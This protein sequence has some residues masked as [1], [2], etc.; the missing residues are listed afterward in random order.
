M[1]VHFIFLETTFR[2]NLLFVLLSTYSFYE[3]SRYG[4]S[5]F[6]KL[7]RL[8]KFKNNFFLNQST[9]VHFIMDLLFYSNITHFLKQNINFV[10]YN[11]NI[12]PKKNKHFT[13]S[14]GAMVRK[15]QSRSQFSYGERYINISRKFQLF[16]NKEQLFQKK[17]IIKIPV[18][19]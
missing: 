19:S 16:D 6:F 17:K 1:A 7:L 13:I 18:L 3:R 2:N 15:K 5:F 11:Y 12:I 10:K 9:I 4:L 14:R 8:S